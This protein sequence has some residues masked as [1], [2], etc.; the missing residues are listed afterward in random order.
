M[1]IWGEAAG[2]L[3][4]P[5]PTLPANTPHLCLHK[6]NTN[7]NTN[8]IQMQLQI[9][10]QSRRGVIFPGSHSAHKYRT[11]MSPPATHFTNLILNFRQIPYTSSVQ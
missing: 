11:R 10:I 4:V 2:A 7:T 9:Q 5:T 8:T 3:I 1:G 6:Y